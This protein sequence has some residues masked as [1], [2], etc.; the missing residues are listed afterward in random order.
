MRIKNNF[1]LICCLSISFP[2]NSNVYAANGDAYAV[3]NT[4]VVTIEEKKFLADL[5]DATKGDNAEWI[6]DRVSYPL[7]VSINGHR[8]KIYSRRDFISNF[9]SIFNE[10]V[11][12]AVIEQRPDDLFKDWS[13]VMVGSGQVWF[14][15]IAKNIKDIQTYRI[16]IAAV[17]GDAP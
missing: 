14:V 10:N 9:S 12:H 15:T 17:N 8:R 6:A 3:V 11:R 2:F 16:V 13:G 5:V 4:N 1:L 7:T